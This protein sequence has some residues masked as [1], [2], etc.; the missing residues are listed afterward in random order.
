[1]R[2]IKTCNHK[3]SLVY[4]TKNANYFAA[5]EDYVYLFD[6]DLIVNLSRNPGIKTASNIWKIPALAKHM[7]ECPE[8]LCLM[9]HDFDEPPVKPSFWMELDSYIKHKKYRDVCFHC[10]AG[11]GRTGTA[12]CS[13]MVA[14]GIDAE[15]AILRLREEYCKLVVETQ[16]QVLYLFMLDSE[17]NGR[18][19]I[20]DPVE[21]HEK[22]SDLTPPFQSFLPQMKNFYTEHE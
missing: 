21:L 7:K 14:N 10:G 3:P 17:L 11:H 16:T 15:S 19:L 18:P 2:F 12:V 8:E 22:I 13:M 9:W 1:M 5:D 4:S 20:E 6:G